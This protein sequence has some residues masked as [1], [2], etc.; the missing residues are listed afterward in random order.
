M[1][2]HYWGWVESP[3]SVDPTDR[4][5]WFMGASHGDDAAIEEIDRWCVE[6]FGSD[7]WRR[8]GSIFWKVDDATDAMAFRLRWC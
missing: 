6:Q 1:G 3:F 7:G 5:H 4:A 2:M 8:M